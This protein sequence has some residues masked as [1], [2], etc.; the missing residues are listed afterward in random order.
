MKEPAKHQK[1][2]F[3]AVYDEHADSLFR[4]VLFKVSNQETAWDLTQDTFLRVWRMLKRGKEIDNLSAYLYQTAQNVV[5]DHYRRRKTESLDR[6]QEAG[7]EPEFTP[8]LEPSEAADAKRYIEWLS[9]LEPIYR[10][11]AILRFV[12]DLPPKE[13]AERLG[14]TQNVVSV[15]LNRVISQI[16]EHFNDE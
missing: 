5:I 8:R 2:A 9:T 11:V 13:I 14:V 7:F 12:D 3:L 10:D 16:R 6:L 4:F 1:E 15:R